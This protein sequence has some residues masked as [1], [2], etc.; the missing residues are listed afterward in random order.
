MHRVNL[1][2]LFALAPRQRADD[3]R[4]QLTHVKVPPGALRRVVIATDG[5]GV[6]VRTRLAG[7]QRR[8]LLDTNKHLVFL[9][10]VI[11][12]LN[13]PGIAQHQNL[14]KHFLWNHNRIGSL[15]ASDP[16]THY[17]RRG[18]SSL[19]T[20]RAYPP[21]FVANGCKCPAFVSPARLEQ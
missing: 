3:F 19:D 16:F 5:F 14:L 4:L 6:A 9:L 11:D 8:S 17:K 1:P 15:P 20:L 13:S 2:A 21:V 12:L 7:P 10:H 18:T